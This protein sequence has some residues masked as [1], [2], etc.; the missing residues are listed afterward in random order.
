MTLNA[1]VCGMDTRGRSFVDRAQVVNLSRDGAMLEDVSCAVNVGD[2]VSVRCEGNSR[3]YRV[4]WAESTATGR[5]VGLAAMGVSTS[6]ENWL[7]AS[8]TDDFLRPRMGSRRKFDRS[9][10]EVAVEMRMKNV[11]TAMW[12]TASDLSEGG[13]RAQVPHA[14]T[15]GTEVNVALWVEGEKVWALGEITHCIYGCGTGIRF[16]NLDRATRERIAAFVAGADTKVSDRRE[17]VI[18]IESF[19]P[20][21][22]AT[23]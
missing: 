16:K 5:R 23:S 21:F 2:Q 19:Y 18:E 12:V 8:G 7:P 11:S 22:S 10:C 17:G 6:A 1:T 14:M 20:A 13:C 4:S 9:I 3:R 15:P